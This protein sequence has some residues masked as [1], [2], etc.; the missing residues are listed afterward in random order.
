[1]SNFRSYGMDRMPPVVK[2]LI[3]INVGV[4]IAQLLLDRSIGLSAYLALYP[5]STPYFSSYQMITHMFTHGGWFHILF[6]MLA[7]WMFGKELE[8]RWG[9]KRFIAFYMMCGIG[10]AVLHLLVQQATGGD[11]A[12]VGASGAVMGIFAAY[13]YLFPDSRMIIFPIPF[14]IKAK[15]AMLGLMAFDLFGGIAG[16]DNIAHFAHLG[17]A[18]TGIIMVWI[19]NKDRSR[20]Y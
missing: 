14:P 1:M 9:G 16:R 7:L 10:A 17:G 5:L 20:F 11:S 8:N 6:N 19:W 15:W 13:A 3:L 2:T 18:I 4:F 12:A